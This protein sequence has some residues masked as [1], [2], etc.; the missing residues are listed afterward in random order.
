MDLNLRGKRAFISGSTSGIGFATAKML[1]TEGVEVYVNGR[2]SENVIKAVNDLQTQVDGAKVFGL[3][4]DFNNPQEVE[5]LFTQLSEVDILI[6]NV[7][8]YNSQSFFETPVQD[9]K[10][11]FQVNFMSGV[12]LSQYYLPKML[13]KNW[14]RIIFISS[15]CAYLVPTDMIS[16]S[17]TKAAMHALSRGLAQLTKGSDVTVNT[18]VPGS[19]LSEGAKDFLSNKA[20]LD[21]T[22][23]MAVEA[24]FFKEERTQ[25]LLERFAKVDEVSSAIIYLC[26]SLSSATNGSVFK[27]DGGSSGGVL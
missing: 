2:S 12:H 13:Q 11:Q 22:T 21:G 19:T 8:I 9:W 25:S 14:G 5:A 3:V 17:T 15:E 20:K 10:D 18:I 26:S 23:P 6:N 4:A 27:V 24:S 16:Y 1:L 7:G